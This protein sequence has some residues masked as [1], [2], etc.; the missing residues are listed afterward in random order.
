MSKSGL[1]GPHPLKPTTNRVPHIWRLYRQ[2][3][4]IRAK[5]EPLHLQDVNNLLRQDETPSS[6]LHT[7]ISLQNAT[8]SNVSGTG[9][10]P[11]RHSLRGGL[12]TS[13]VSDPV[14]IKNICSRSSLT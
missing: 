4:D 12:H 8:W 5:R 11:I 14:Q 1:R 7:G 6:K 13:N 9:F 10:G 3:W 2:M